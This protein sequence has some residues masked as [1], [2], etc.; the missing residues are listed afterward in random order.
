MH[1]VV[2]VVEGKARSG[3]DGAAVDTTMPMVVAVLE[4]PGRASLDLG[5]AVDVTSG[6]TLSSVMQVCARDERIA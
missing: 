3:M 1:E 4:A 2:V 6:H 5:H